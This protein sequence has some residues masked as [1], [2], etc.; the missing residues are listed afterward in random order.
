MKILT[1]QKPKIKN[2]PQ[3]RVTRVLRISKNM[4][5]KHETQIKARKARNHSYDVVASK[6]SFKKYELEFS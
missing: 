3:Q 1:T 6:T 4:K 2:I 5:S